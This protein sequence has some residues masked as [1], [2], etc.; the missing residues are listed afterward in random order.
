MKRPRKQQQEDCPQPKWETML[1]ADSAW[2]NTTRPWED[3]PVCSRKPT[4]EIGLLKL[5]G[6]GFFYDFISRCLGGNGRDNL[7]T[8]GLSFCKG[9]NRKQV[10]KTGEITKAW[11]ALAALAE[12]PSSVPGSHMEAH[13]H[14][15]SSSRWLNTSFWPPRA[16]L[17]HTTHLGTHTYTKFKKSIFKNKQVVSFIFKEKIQFPLSPI[18]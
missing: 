11:R 5:Q 18:H 1:W 9:K 15:N 16:L 7:Y 17:T 8:D 2:E 12:D 4:L 13:D 10:I 6:L 3:L 14:C